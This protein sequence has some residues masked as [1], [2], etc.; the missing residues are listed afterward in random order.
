MDTKLKKSTAFHPQTNGQTKVVNK[1]IIH[2]LRG[3]CSKHPKLWDEQLYY[4]QHAFNRAKHSSTLTLPFEAC[5]GY[6]PKSPLDFIFQKDVAVDGHSDI[7]KAK[8]FIEQIQLIHQ[9]V[10]EQLENNQGKYKAR[11]DNH[12]WII[13][14]K[15]VMKCDYTSIRKY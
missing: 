1:T 14:F 3:Y 13:N 15:L 7:D 2:F 12:R 4:I 11:H 9:T 10:Q 6:L 5:L 8:K